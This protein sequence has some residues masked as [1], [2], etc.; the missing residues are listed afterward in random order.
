MDSHCTVCGAPRP[1]G[2]LDAP[3]DE[4]C[5]L[6]GGLRGPSSGTADEVHPALQH[7]LGRA[8]PGAERAPAPPRASEEPL[9]PAEAAPSVPPPPDAGWKVEHQGDTLRLSWQS[10]RGRAGLAV[11]ALLGGA[12]LVAVL[13][14][15]TRPFGADPF[16]VATVGAALALLL[17]CYGLLV[18]AVNRTYVEASRRTGLRAWHGPLP[19]FSSF[20]SHVALGAIRQLYGFRPPQP[21][22]GRTRRGS[23]RARH[24]LRVLKGD[25]TSVTLVGSG[26]TLQQVHFLERALEAHLGIHHAPSLPESPASAEPRS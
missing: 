20:K 9:P 10:T 16:L 3:G 8:A 11:L 25:D 13:A 12:L 26:L 15:G 21:P 18:K 2:T 14:V 4:G 5:A 24:E 6:C 17:P 22:T 23:P 1:V 7:K 19:W